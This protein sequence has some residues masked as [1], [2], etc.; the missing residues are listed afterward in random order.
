[1][2]PHC[3]K[4]SALI[5]NLYFNK[6]DDV[7]NTEQD[8]NVKSKERRIKI[9]ARSQETKGD[10]VEYNYLKLIYDVNDQRLKIIM[11]T[12]FDHLVLF[13][14]SV[15]SAAACPKL[16]YHKILSPFRFRFSCAWKLSVKGLPCSIGSL[17]SLPLSLSNNQHV[18]ESFLVL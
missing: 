5:L 14:S 8:R 15:H 17:G 10:T 11:R 1:M 18:D 13:S 2:P 16:A 6:L 12:S 7:T 4:G 9:P 3:Y